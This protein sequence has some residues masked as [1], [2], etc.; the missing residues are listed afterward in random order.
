M[1]NTISSNTAELY[2]SVIVNFKTT[3]SDLKNIIYISSCT[4]YF[5]IQQAIIEIQNNTTPIEKCLIVLFV[6]EF[7]ITFYKIAKLNEKTR[8]LEHRLQTLQA[9]KN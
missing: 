9:C 2:Y 5:I 7:I 6:Y 8:N 3:I 4:F 1:N